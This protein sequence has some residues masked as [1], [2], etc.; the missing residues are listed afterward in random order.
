MKGIILAGG[1]GTRLHPITKA[2]SKQLIPIN[3]KPMIYYIF[4]IP[5]TSQFHDW[6]SFDSASDENWGPSI[7]K[8]VAPFWNLIF[9]ILSD[10]CAIFIRDLSVG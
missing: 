9:D 6:N 3:D 4:V 7:H 10:L 2:I 5:I 1:S 8:Y